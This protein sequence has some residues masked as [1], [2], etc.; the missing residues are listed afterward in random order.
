MVDIRGAQLEA[1]DVVGF[2]FLQDG[3]TVRGLPAMWPTDENSKGIIFLDEINRADKS[4]T[5]AF[6]QLLTDRTI[7]TDID[8]PYKLPDGWLIAAAINPD[9]DVYG[10][11]EMNT[12]LRDRFVKVNVD[13][14]LKALLD[15]ANKKQW[16]K[17]V[18]NFL[19]SNSFVYR[20]ASSVS[21]N[22][23]YVASRGFEALSAIEYSSA[24]EQVKQILR[25][26]ILGT[27]YATLYT[28][29][30]DEEDKVLSIEDVL[31]DPRKLR[32]LKSYHDGG[33]V[34]GDK[35]SVFMN[36]ALS[37]E[38]T[39]TEKQFVDILNALPNSELITFYSKRIIKE[40]NLSDFYTVQTNYHMMLDK[41]PELKQ[42][43]SEM[44]GEVVRSSDEETTSE[45]V[46][47]G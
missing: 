44:A 37:Y 2:P 42:R 8:K 43:I 39:L 20:K 3:R 33:I 40:G 25:R 35:M 15:Y 32:E 22:E 9:D 21:E 18:I 11:N 47:N 12:A 45:E 6:L 30:V 1:P 46:V 7:L 23:Q 41:Y 38:G 27:K 19:A 28:N 36:S 13:F 5:N 24:T 17:N 26:S 14:N 16:H 10:T 31:S 4:V 29:L 34:R